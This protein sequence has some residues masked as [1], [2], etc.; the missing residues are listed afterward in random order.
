MA[1]FYPSL[2]LTLSLGDISVEGWDEISE[3]VRLEAPVALGLPGTFKLFGDNTPNFRAFEDVILNEGQLWKGNHKIRYCPASSDGV[4]SFPKSEF[5]LAGIVGVKRCLEIGDN[6]VNSLSLGFLSEDAFGTGYHPIDLHRGC[7]F[8]GVH[9]WEC[10][11]R[12]SG[13]AGVRSKDDVFDKRGTSGDGKKIL[14]MDQ[15]DSAAATSWTPGEVFDLPDWVR[16]YRR[17]LGMRQCSFEGKESS[18]L[19]P[20]DDGDESDQHPRC[21]RAF[22][23]AERAHVFEEKASSESAAPEISDSWAAIPPSE[24]TLPEVSSS[25]AEEAG[26]TGVCSDFEEVRRLHFVACDRLMFELLRQGP[27]FRNFWMRASPLGS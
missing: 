26:S 15:G 24:Y 9:S 11:S 12:R 13:T 3:D 10:R 4:E 1:F 21:D 16:R 7:R 23:G 18:A 5:S 27:G 14:W 20:R 17:F 25:G 2:S 19:E 8:L 22:S 6:T